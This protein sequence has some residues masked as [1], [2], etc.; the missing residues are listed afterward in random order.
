M[1]KSQISTTNELLGLAA[2]LYQLSDVDAIIDKVLARL[3]ELYSVE[4]KL[5][6]EA[7]GEISLPLKLRDTTCA[8]ICLGSSLRVKRSDAKRHPE[9]GEGSLSAQ[10]MGIATPASRARN[11]VT[12]LELFMNL[13]SQRIDQLQLTMDLSASHERLLEQS[14]YMSQIFSTVSHELRT[15][16]TNVIGFSELML[17]RE[18]DTKTQKQYLSEIARSAR[19]LSTLVNDF[20]D[21]SRVEASGSIRLDDC[22]PADIDWIAER[23]WK[24]LN[25]EL[26][27]TNKPAEIEWQIAK[28]L[29][30]INADSDAMI[31]V[32]INLFSNA[33]KY[34]SGS[35]IVCAISVTKNLVQ[36][37]VEDKGIGIP[38]DM[39]DSIFDR[40]VRVDNGVTRE[41]GG[42]GLG[43]WI[44]RQIIEAHGGKIYCKSKLGAGTQVCF[45][46]PYIK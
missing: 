16:L 6:A 37:K 33:L 39:L 23:A 19:R 43:L 27:L 20:L 4:T 36:V 45:T 24:D 18:L 5:S 15:P 31:R 14:R 12:E 25:A 46:V 8:Y 30:K 32:F 11:D 40:F 17:S 41:T 34:G 42:T 9:S 2:E 35:K 10:G 29:P 21:L 13:V 22:E 26:I 38:Q 44:C 1:A 28:N 3:Q 7:E